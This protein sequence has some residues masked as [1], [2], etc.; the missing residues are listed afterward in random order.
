MTEKTIPLFIIDAS[1]LV[2]IFEGNND[3]KAMDVLKKIGEM[4]AQGL[5]FKAVTTWPC[6]LR[7]LWKANPKG[8][9]EHI[10]SAMDVFDIVVTQE[11]DYKNEKKVLDDTIMFANRISGGLS[12]I[13]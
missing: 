10:Q 11:V 9:I 3:T 12:G 2:N 1:A 6:F 13:R 4:K 5:P 8:R 7:A